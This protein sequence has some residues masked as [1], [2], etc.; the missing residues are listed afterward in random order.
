MAANTRRP[1]ETR[2]FD[3]PIARVT[4]KAVRA[5]RGSKKAPARKAGIEVRIAFKEASKAREGSLRSDAEVEGAYTV[6]LDMA[7]STAA[8]GSD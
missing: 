5:R 2:F 3:T 4:A 8:T 1:L 7:A 6:H